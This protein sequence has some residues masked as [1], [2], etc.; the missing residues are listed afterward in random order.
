MR[1]IPT[2]GIN[3]DHFLCLDIIY[4]HFI[5]IKRV[6]LEF[7]LKCTRN[8]DQ[9]KYL[10]YKYFDLIL[11]IIEKPGHIQ[12]CPLRNTFSIIKCTN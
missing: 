4:S 5:S 12:G 3:I 9:S 2:I 10:S 8:P 1:P 6:E 11:L 7:F